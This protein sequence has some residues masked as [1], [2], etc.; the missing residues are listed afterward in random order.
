[1]IVS[2]TWRAGVVF[3]CGYC[4]GSVQFIPR[5]PK[6]LVLTIALVSPFVAGWNLARLGQWIAKGKP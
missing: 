5:S 2:R 3:V 1:M 6:W 4:V